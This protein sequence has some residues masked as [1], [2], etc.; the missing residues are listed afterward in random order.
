MVLATNRVDHLGNNLLAYGYD[1][2][3]RLTNHPSAA[4]ARPFTGMC[5][6]STNW[7]E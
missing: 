6:L 2:N 3:N 7:N 1:L 4:K 5:G